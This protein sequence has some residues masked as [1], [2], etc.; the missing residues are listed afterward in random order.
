MIDIHEKSVNAAKEYGHPGNLVI[1]TNIAGFIN[2]ADA[3]VMQGV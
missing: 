1:G 3:M 2:V